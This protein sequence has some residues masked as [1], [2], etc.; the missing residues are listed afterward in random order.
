MD[1]VSEQSTSRKP[2]RKD[3][4]QLK[5]THKKRATVETPETR[6]SRNRDLSELLARSLAFSIVRVQKE[7]GSD[8]AENILRV[9][10]DESF[11][12][13]VLRA[14]APTIKECIIVME[15]E[16]SSQK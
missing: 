5:I 4:I 6:I 14:T 11:D 7:C 8:I 16:M 15:K 9:V 13:K 1:N 12:P 2:R 10:S 3:A